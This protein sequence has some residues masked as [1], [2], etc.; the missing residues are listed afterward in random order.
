MCTVPLLLKFLHL[1][2]CLSEG[3]SI[4]LFAHAVYVGFNV[5]DREGSLGHKLINAA[6]YMSGSSACTAQQTE[7]EVFIFF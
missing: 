7:T 5:Q 4:R 6:L 1:T 2:L 3:S